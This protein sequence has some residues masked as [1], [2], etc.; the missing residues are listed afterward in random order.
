VQLYRFKR[1]G[2]HPLHNI[3]EGKDLAGGKPIE[4]I[5]AP[6]E[7]A[8]AMAQGVGAPSKPV[9]AV[10]DAVTVGQLIAEAG[11]FVGTR[12]HASVSG[13]V[14]AIMEMPTPG[15]NDALHIV[16]KNDGLDTGRDAFTTARDTAA[17]DGKDIL[18]AIRLAGIGGMGGA[19]FPTHVKMSIPEGKKCEYLLINGSECEP[20]LTADQRLMEEMSDKI[21]R[22]IGYAMRAL[23]VS[24]CK[25]GV[26]NNKPKA[27]SAMTAAA[28]SVSGVEICPLKTKYPQGA[29][30]QL[31]SALTGREVPRGG[32]PIDCGV[33]VLNTGTCAA[34]C[35]AVEYG[36]PLFERVVT[37]TGCVKEPK[38]LLCPLGTSF[39]DAIAYCGGF[40]EPIAKLISGGPMMGFAQFTDAVTVAKGTSGILALNDTIANYYDEWPCT[41]CGKCVA[42]CPIGIMPLMV[43][44]YIRKGRADMAENY[45][46]MD[47]IECG[48]CSFICPS[49]RHLTQ[50]CRT[51]KREIL[52]ARAREKNKGGDK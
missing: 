44:A 52:A 46:A 13:T 32:L 23:N 37:V 11:G 45:N 16:I 18:E 42:A 27:I 20:Y 19:G 28:K 49:K 36:K 33:V 6:N 5:A 2:V 15:G 22:G 35:D 43:D 9:V 8:I 25:V 34:I 1:G 31:T 38:N 48:C 3:H 30:K 29:E 40:S 12:I 21:L 4:P 41:H 10:G 14:T 24:K 51:A 39:K 50:S 17:M 26:E 47:C 7:V